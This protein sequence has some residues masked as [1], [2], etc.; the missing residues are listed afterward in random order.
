MDSIKLVYIDFLETWKANKE[1]CGA[2]NYN[3]HR[4]VPAY[5]VL[6]DQYIA[7]SYRFYRQSLIIY[8]RADVIYI[9]RPGLWQ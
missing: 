5:C 2:D 3:Y 7:E 4:S 1:K 8:K 6:I 9:W